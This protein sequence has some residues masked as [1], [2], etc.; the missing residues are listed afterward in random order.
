MNESTH[1][2]STATEP[3]DR[4]THPTSAVLSEA[5]YFAK[6]VKNS[7]PSVECLIML[8]SIRYVAALALVLQE[9]H[10]SAPRISLCNRREYRKP[11]LQL[12]GQF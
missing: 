3:Q 4:G 6:R 1:E 7:R 10:Q 11:D 8:H 2:E 5:R 12:N 9:Q